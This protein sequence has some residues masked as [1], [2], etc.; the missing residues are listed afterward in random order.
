MIWRRSGSGLDVPCGGDRLGVVAIE[1]D[2]VRRGRVPLDPRSVY[3]K[4][5]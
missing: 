1:L 4:F 2:A 5:L 3:S